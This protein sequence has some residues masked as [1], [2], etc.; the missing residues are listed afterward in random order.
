ML[1]TVTSD[2]LSNRIPSSR[3]KSRARIAYMRAMDAQSLDG[4]PAGGSS[5]HRFANP[6]RFLRLAANMPCDAL[7]TCNPQGISGAA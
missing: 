1:M 3:L 7:R 5:L 6:G 4:A 2:E